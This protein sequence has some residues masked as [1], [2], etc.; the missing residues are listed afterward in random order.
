MGL[1]C[2]GRKERRTRYLQTGQV[3]CLPCDGILR[4]LTLFDA[5]SSITGRLS[6]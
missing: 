1:C 3:T 5:A 6:T 4:M 2:W